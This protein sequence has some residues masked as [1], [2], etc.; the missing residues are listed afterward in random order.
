MCGI[1]VHQDNLELLSSS[2]D[3]EHNSTSVG[4][5]R[6]VPSGT[7]MELEESCSAV[8]QSCI[9]AIL[10]ELDASNGGDNELISL[11]SF[12]TVVSVPTGT[13][14]GDNDQV[15]QIVLL[16]DQESPIDEPEEATLSCTYSA[17]TEEVPNA[18]FLGQVRAGSKE[19]ERKLHADGKLQISRKRF[20]S[21]E[22]SL[23]ARY[24]T[25]Q[26]V[27]HYVR[28]SSAPVSQSFFEAIL[29][30][31]SKRSREEQH[32][33]LPDDGMDFGSRKRLN[34]AAHRKHASQL[35]IHNSNEQSST[36]SSLTYK[37]APLAFAATCSA[38]SINLDATTISGSVSHYDTAKS[39]LSGDEKPLREEASCDNTISEVVSFS[40]DDSAGLGRPV[41][42]QVDCSHLDGSPEAASPTI[43]PDTEDLGSP[44]EENSEELLE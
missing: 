37:T 9:E 20:L 31:Q 44:I 22:A 21:E 12:E 1:S 29:E 26:Q 7:N 43:T 10:L 28:K 36:Q 40:M 18:N 8:V 2:L 23:N 24:R 39:R 35:S 19:T 41:E 5:K 6:C 42:L 4:D 15:A 34:L 30:H 32:E 27:L 3:L 25:R 13:T 11:Q 38:P 16:G 33:K 17:E 14:R